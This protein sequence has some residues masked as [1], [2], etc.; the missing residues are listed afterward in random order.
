MVD[1]Q[2]K[3]ANFFLLV[4]VLNK[5]NLTAITAFFQSIIWHMLVSQLDLKKNL[6]KWESVLGE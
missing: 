6:M 5:K 2:K 3:N 1:I 4:P